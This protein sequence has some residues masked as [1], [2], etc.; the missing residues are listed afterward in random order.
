[1]TKRTLKKF[2]IIAALLCT[3]IFT[4]AL[5]AM[6]ELENETFNTGTYLNLDRSTQT[7]F[8][9]PTDFVVK[10]INFILEIIAAV[11]IGVII[12]GGLMLIISSG[13]ETA[14]SRGKD[15]IFNAVIGLLIVLAALVITMFVQALLYQKPEATI[16]LAVSSIFTL[17]KA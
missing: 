1:M 17:Q 16:P 15:I 11:I 12:I 5:P 8:T 13:D 2:P 4:N 3:L 9:D 7:P 6:A 10:A 14:I